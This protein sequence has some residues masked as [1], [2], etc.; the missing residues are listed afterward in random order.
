MLNLDTGSH[1]A[2]SRRCRQAGFPPLVAICLAA[3]SGARLEGY[4]EQT[5]TLFP[6][7]KMPG[8]SRVETEDFL[9]RHHVPLAV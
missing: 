9:G 5:L 4:R 1:A 2:H 8:L 7:S 6:G 3:P